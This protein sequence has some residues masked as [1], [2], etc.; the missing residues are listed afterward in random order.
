MSDC[1]R[2]TDQVESILA[3]TTDL[4]RVIRCKECRCYRFGGICVNPRG[5]V[6]AHEDGYCS[7]GKWKDDG[8]ME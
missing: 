2:T 3:R 1:M 8:G 4:V 7:E 6:N 5:M